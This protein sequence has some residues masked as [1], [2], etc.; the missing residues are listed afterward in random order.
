LI[1][2]LP[3]HP[4]SV[5]KDRLTQ[6][7]QV[8]DINGAYLGEAYYPDA[9]VLRMVEDSHLV[10]D[11]V[12]GHRSIEVIGGKFFRS[13]VRREK[14]YNTLIVDPHGNQANRYK[15]VYVDEYYSLVRQEDEGTYEWKIIR[16]EEAARK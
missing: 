11:F 8:F 9:Y 10:I 7:I 16:V 13:H 12:P 6:V 5:T 1:S 14:L 3:T 2:I 15:V 4:Q